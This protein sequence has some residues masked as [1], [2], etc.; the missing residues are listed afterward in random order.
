MGEEATCAKIGVTSPITFSLAFITQLSC[1]YRM[2][3][4]PVSQ[5][6][7]LNLCRCSFALECYCS[8]YDSI[9]VFLNR[10]K[11]VLEPYCSL[12]SKVG[13]THVKWAPQSS[14]TNA[15]IVYLMILALPTR[16]VPELQSPHFSL[17]S[18]SVFV[19]VVLSATSST[20][21]V[22]ET[23]HSSEPVLIAQVHRLVL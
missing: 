5:S 7:K 22:D 19:S 12:I 20:S 3:I 8:T 21:P 9:G 16:Y 6:A 4:L 2:V 23:V 18:G 14:S 17:S 13:D 10:C 11:D 1:R 15:V